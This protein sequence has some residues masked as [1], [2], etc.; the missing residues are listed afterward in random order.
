MRATE[1][2]RKRASKPVFDLGFGFSFMMTVFKLVSFTVWAPQHDVD[3]RAYIEIDMHFPTA[4]L[5]SL[6]VFS[7]ALIAVLAAWPGLT[8]TCRGK[9]LA[10]LV[11]FLLPVVS[12]GILRG[13]GTHLWL[14]P[15]DK[16]IQ[17]LLFLQRAP[18]A[19]DDTLTAS[20]KTDQY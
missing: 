2:G 7:V 4:L 9:V 17:R 11:L 16:L 1:S 3:A 12:G 18:L 10:F 20:R 19:T 6:I 14:R 15:R 8:A 5:L 13:K